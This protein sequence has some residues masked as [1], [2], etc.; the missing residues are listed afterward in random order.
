MEMEEKQN[1]FSVS[2]QAYDRHTVKLGY[3]DHGYN[4][5]TVITNK[6]HQLVWISISYQWNFIC[7]NRDIVITVKLY[8][9]KYP[10][11]T[12]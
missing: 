5:V 9:V 12:E 2:M 1:T 10:L 8:V 3:K 4:E 6:I 11:G 7:Y